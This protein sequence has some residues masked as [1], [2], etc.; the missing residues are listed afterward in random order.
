M[1][2]D[3]NTAGGNFVCRPQYFYVDAVV[4]KN[5]PQDTDAFEM[6][7]LGNQPAVGADDLTGEKGGVG[8]GEE[9]EEAGDFCGGT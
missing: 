6:G 4:R 2:L 1:C 7:G 5:P 8:S 9:Q 3:Q